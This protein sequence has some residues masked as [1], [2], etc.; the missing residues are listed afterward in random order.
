M[1]LLFLYAKGFAQTTDSTKQVIRLRCSSTPDPKKQPLIVINDKVYSMKLMGGIDPDLIT[2]INIFKG[3]EAIQ[4]YGTKAQYGVIAI[5]SKKGAKWINVNSLMKNKR[6]KELPIVYRGQVLQRPFIFTV[7]GKEYS[8][9]IINGEND[10]LK[11]PKI[12]GK[13]LS[14][15]ETK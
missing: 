1:F 7:K 15:T 10:Q 5:T 14:I 12:T 6:D 2:A 9:T 4:K 13:Y 8:F 3:K 11:D